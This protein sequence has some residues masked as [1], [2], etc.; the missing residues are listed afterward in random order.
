[1]NFQQPDCLQKHLMLL[2]LLSLCQR[3]SV[4]VQFRKRALLPG[5]LLKLRDTKLIQFQKTFLQ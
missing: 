1:M 2:H 5:L 3:A 4:T